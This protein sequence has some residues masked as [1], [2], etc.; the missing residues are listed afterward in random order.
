MCRCGRSEIR[1]FCDGTHAT[2]KFRAAGT[3]EG[4]RLMG[5]WAAERASFYVPHAVGQQ[6]S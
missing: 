5:S 1:P 6:V 3:S 2:T 4:R